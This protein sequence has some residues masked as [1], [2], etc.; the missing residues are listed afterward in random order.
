MICFTKSD[1]KNYILNDMSPIYNCHMF[2]NSLL[3]ILLL[4]RQFHKDHLR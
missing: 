1:K 2:D 3:L 4:I